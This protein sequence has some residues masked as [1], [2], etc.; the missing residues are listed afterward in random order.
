MSQQ[1]VHVPAGGLC[2][3]YTHTD[4]AS[5]PYPYPYS[6]LCMIQNGEGHLCVC[7]CVTQDSLQA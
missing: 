6:S 4:R 1:A 3:L 5:K 7:V 2:P